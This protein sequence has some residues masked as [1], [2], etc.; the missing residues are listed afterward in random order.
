MNNEE[1]KKSRTRQYYRYGDVRDKINVS[2]Q[3]F[4]ARRFLMLRKANEVIGVRQYYEYG[5][6]RKKYR[7]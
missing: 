5:E 7:F 4:L 6:L 3:V 2:K 1:N